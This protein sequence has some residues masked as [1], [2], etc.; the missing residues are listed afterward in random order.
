MVAPSGF[1]VKLTVLFWA[2]GSPKIL[3]NLKFE[4]ELPANSRALTR[5]FFG[6]NPIR[7]GGHSVQKSK[8]PF[9]FGDCSSRLAALGGI[10][11]KPSLAT[12]RL[13]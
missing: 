6:R 1:E 10:G 13:G 3:M 12:F 8:C 11:G 5:K 7:R 4:M 9:G 2:T